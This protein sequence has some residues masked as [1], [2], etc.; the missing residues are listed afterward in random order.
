MLDGFRRA[1]PRQ[2]RLQFRDRTP[3]PAALLVQETDLERGITQPVA[4][5]HRGAEF[6]FTQHVAEH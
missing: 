5:L 2:A 4:D 1:E 6:P 3:R